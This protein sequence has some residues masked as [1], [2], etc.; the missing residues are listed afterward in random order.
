V[1]E[2]KDQGLELTVRWNGRPGWRFGGPV[3]GDD[4][5]EASNEV[6]TEESDPDS[7]PA[8]L[9]FLPVS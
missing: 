1:R 6:R 5:S 4:S 3:A 2:V 9:R 7:D 8:L